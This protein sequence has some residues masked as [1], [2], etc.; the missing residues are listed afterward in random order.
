MKKIT[1]I[2]LI[3]SILTLTLFAD[4]EAGG[5]GGAYLRM[6]ADARVAALGNAGTMILDDVNM[7][8][9]N[10]AS[11][12]SI[13]TRQFSSSF[14]FLSLDRSYQTLS[15]GVSLPPNAGM[16]VSWIH[17]GVDDIM[18]RNYSNDAGLDYTWSQNAFIIGFGLNITPWMSLGLT[19]KVLSD[20]LAS[21]SSSGFF[22]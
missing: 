13:K 7:N 16:S 9:G 11:I 5:A 3:L 8:L 19:G 4:D 2:L 1:K 20:Q 10:P 21:S 22:C 12:P 14:Q 6:P 18:G 17:A 15:F